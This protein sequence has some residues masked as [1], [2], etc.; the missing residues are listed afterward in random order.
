M[1]RD[2]L[3]GF[4]PGDWVQGLDLTTLERCSGSYVTDDLRDRADDLVWRLRWG[5]D[6][7]YLYLLL[8]FQS[9]VDPW[10]ALRIQTYIGLLYQDLIRA[11]QLSA[12]GRLPRCC[13]SCST[14]V[15]RVGAPPRRSSRSS[16]SSR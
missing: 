13:R 2:L 10:M 6:W 11:D 8:E 16:R 4:V 9:T 1:V 5:S 7:L 14:M 15:L 12:A 3:R